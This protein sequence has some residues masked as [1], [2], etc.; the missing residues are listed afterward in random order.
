MKPLNKIVC[1]CYITMDSTKINGKINKV[2][3]YGLP[4]TFYGGRVEGITESK[5]N[6]G[7]E[8]Y[9]FLKKGINCYEVF[10]MALKTDLEKP[11][12]E[13]EKVVEQLKT[14]PLKGDIIAGKLS[15]LAKGKR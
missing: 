12:T 9:L 4:L 3:H 14:E 2:T 15:E 1:K 6:C 5:C 8:Y 11:K 13:V 7:R 10:D